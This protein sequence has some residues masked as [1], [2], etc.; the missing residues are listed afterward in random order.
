MRVVLI[1]KHFSKVLGGSEIQC[2]QIAE[3]LVK[4][5]I[6]LTYIA[7]EGLGSKSDFG[8]PV[9]EVDYKAVSL[10]REI[11]NLKPDIVYWRLNKRLLAPVMKELGDQAIPFVFSVSHIN[12]LQ[13][14]AYK[15]IPGL[16]MV[17]KL[18]RRLSHLLRGWHYAKALKRIDGMI[19]N[20]EDHLAEIKS[21]N[22]TYIP[23]S[24]YLTFEEFTWP[25]PYVVW[26]GNLKAHKHPEDFISL[27][28]DLQ[29]AGVD[30][31]MV[32]N[33]QQEAY[34]YIEKGENLPPNF[35]YLGSQHIHKT[36]GV[37]RGSEFL[38]HTCEPEGFPN[39]FLQAWGF[40]KPVVSQFF[41]P[42]GKI[43]KADVGFVSGN[44]EKLK[45][46]VSSLLNSE[47]LLKKKGG[48]AKKLIEDEFIKERN[49]QRLLQFLEV[50]LQRKER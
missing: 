32:G 21:N 35:H 10:A 17:Q 31:L 25:R 44:Y 43:E 34:Q 14:Y 9:K 19:C 28:R 22:K 15:P 1:N 49:I 16:G 8:Y 4:E 27:A 20:N 6:D 36:N 48:N 37:I 41:D 3:G 30:F 46:D 40:G 45:E 23:N 29:T 47:E 33:I 11:A 7:A 18:K 50:T 2:H 26:V 12:D 42:G 13:P 39:V 5:G 24:P 38:V